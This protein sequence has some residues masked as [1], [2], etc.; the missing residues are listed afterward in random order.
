MLEPRASSQ[1]SKDSNNRQYRS[2]FENVDIRAEDTD[3]L[4]SAAFAP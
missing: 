3:V 2:I 4:V 1:I